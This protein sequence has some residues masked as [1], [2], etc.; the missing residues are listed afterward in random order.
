VEE[1]TRKEP[2]VRK[3]VF[4]KKFKKIETEG[5]LPKFRPVLYKKIHPQQISGYIYAM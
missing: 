4:L 2:A 5:S 1:R 3:P